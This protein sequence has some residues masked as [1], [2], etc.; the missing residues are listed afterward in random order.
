MT[1]EEFVNT[2]SRLEEMY[3]K[4]LNDTQLS[5]WFDELKRYEIDKY[6]RAIGEYIK[7]NR[8]MP[9]IADILDKL[10]NLKPLGVDAPEEEIKMK[11]CGTCK[12]S[13]LVR[14]IK[15][16]YE[17]FC[18]CFCNN[19]KAWNNFTLF[20]EY[21]DVFYYRVPRNDVAPLDFDISQ[22]NF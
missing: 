3:N 10:K 7:Q 21:K 5:F 13:G 14:Y 9:T 12:G 15:D 1:R 18:R 6:K 8:T 2:T 16:G 22:I 17:Y 4:K 19:S 11:P 20:R